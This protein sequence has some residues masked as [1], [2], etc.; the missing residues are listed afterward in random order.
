MI[1][2]YPKLF[3]FFSIVRKGTWLVLSLSLTIH[4]CMETLWDCHRLINR[5]SA[6]VT[7]W[8]LTCMGIAVRHRFIDHN[9]ILDYGHCVWSCTRL[10]Y[11]RIVSK[12]ICMDIMYQPKEFQYIM[13]LVYFCSHYYFLSSYYYDLYYYYTC[14]CTMYPHLRT[15]FMLDHACPI[16][17]QSALP[18][19]SLLVPHVHTPTVSL[20]HRVHSC[21]LHKRI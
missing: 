16:K 4:H 15:K 1:G 10:L 11:S 18:P 20:K 14:L 7:L 8:C 9:K 17:K 5:W 12:D 6:P 2:N 21:C 13:Y 3:F 19:H